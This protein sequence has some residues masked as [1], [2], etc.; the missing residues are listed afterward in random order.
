M[1]ERDLKQCLS[2]FYEEKSLP[3]QRAARL[4]A[5]ASAGVGAAPRGTSGPR[6]TVVIGSLA[7]CVFA[8]ALLTAYIVAPSDM[9]ETRVAKSTQIDSPLLRKTKSATAGESAPRLV[10]V[11]FRADWCTACPKMAPVYDRLVECYREQSVLF[12]VFDLTND[13]TRKQSELLASSLG[14][15]WLCGESIRTGMIKLVDRQDRRVLASATEPDELSDILAK[16]DGCL[17]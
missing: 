3:A 1:S 2:Q 15:D 8:T 11:N 7:L 6:W 17:Q 4:S 16:L 13:G 5:L 12:V 9:T 14:I 10:A